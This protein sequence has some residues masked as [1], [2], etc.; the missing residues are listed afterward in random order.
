MNPPFKGSD[1]PLA[2]DLFG[3]DRLVSETQY[4]LGSTCGRGRRFWILP[5]RFTDVYIH[6]TSFMG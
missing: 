4:I 6:H 3:L 2:S 1:H 5:D